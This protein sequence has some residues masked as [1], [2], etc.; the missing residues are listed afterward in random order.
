MG[1]TNSNKELTTSGIECGGE[2]GVRL[3]LT[4]APDIMTNPVDIVLV[5][6]RSRSMAGS[7]LANLKSGAKRFIEIIDEATDTPGDGQIGGGSRIGIVSFASTAT[8]DT[9]LI[10][11]VEELDDAV[12][13]LRAGGRTNHSDAFST[14]V[15]MFDSDSTHGRIIVMFTDGETTEGPSPVPITDAAKA[16]GIIIYCIGLSGSGGFDADALEAW[17]S[18]PSSSYVAITPDDSELEDLFE[19]LAANITRPG[20]TEISIRDTLNPCFNIVALSK[21]SVGSAEILSDTSLVWRIGALGVKEN[22]GAYLDFTVRHTG[23]CTGDVEVN[24]S[25]SYTDAEGNSVSFPSRTIKVECDIVERPETCP[26]PVPITIDGCTDTLEF[27]AGDISLES[28]GRI[29]QLDVT[30][31]NICPGKRVA[32]AVILT[33]VDDCIEYRRGMKTLLIPAHLGPHCRDV[34]VRCIKFVLPEVLAVN[35]EEHGSMCKQRK[36][37][38]RF[39]ANYVDSGFECCSSTADTH[40]CRDKNQE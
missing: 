9:G 20:A 30:L 38:A 29:L 18:E 1:I 34:T 22:E 7:P 28:L 15:G 32:L 2:F 16:D 24:E 35:G 17:A 25:V 23:S 3:S 10:T 13:A 37:H 4:A 26:E 31:K 40:P 12:D 36:L 14:A 5:L 27:D 21:P 8:A 6:D 19:D 11:S 33:E 39:I